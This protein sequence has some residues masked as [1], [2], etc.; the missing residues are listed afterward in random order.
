M[1]RLSPSSRTGTSWFSWTPQLGGSPQRYEI[2][3]R[4]FGRA[5]LPVSNEFT[6]NGYTGSPAGPSHTIA[7]ADG[8]FAVSWDTYYGGDRYARLHATSTGK[9]AWH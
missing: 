4:I 6:V 8:G 5:R 9:A 2:H 1:T 3:A 7:L